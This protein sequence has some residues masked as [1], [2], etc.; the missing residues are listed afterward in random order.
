MSNNV[1]EHAAANLA[2]DLLRVL[3]D[4]IR[5]LQEPWHSTSEAAQQAVIDRLRM[6]VL[7]ASAKAVRE[8]ASAGFTSFAGSLESLAIKDGIKASLKLAPVAQW[9]DV[10]VEDVGSSVL[11]VIARPLDYAGSI[12]EIRAD[13]DQA[14]LPIAEPAPESGE[15]VEDGEPEDPRGGDSLL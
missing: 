6:G 1:T 9:L 13:P 5:T 8:I 10:L 12:D 14:E 7:Q 2:G 3:V 11:L 4:E 15:E